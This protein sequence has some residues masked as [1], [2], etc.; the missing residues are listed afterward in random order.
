MISPD[1]QSLLRILE[2]VQKLVPYGMIRQ[3]LRV[4]NAATMIN[5][6]TKLLL[7]K[8]SVT[9]WT[10]WIGISNSVDEGMNMLQQ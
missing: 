3:A 5:G 8:L 2:N 6:I 1:G 10:N 7:A 4:G 9:A